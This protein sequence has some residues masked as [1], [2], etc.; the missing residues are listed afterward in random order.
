MN[1]WS[2]STTVRNPERIPDFCTAVEAVAE[3]EWNRSSQ[4]EFMYE[5]IRRRFYEPSNMTDA[6]QKKF[7]DPEYRLSRNEAKEIFDEQNYEDPP[8]RGRT[9][10]APL[11]DIGVV[12]IADRVRVTSIGQ[13]LIAGTISLQDVLLNYALKW[14]VPTPGHRRFTHQ[15]GFNIRPFVGVLALIT[16]VNQLW[17]DMGNEAVGVSKEEFEIFAPTLIAHEHIELFAQRIISIR[18]EVRSQRSAAARLAAAENGFSQ[19]L[20]WCSPNQI[21]TQTDRNNLRDFGDNAIRYFRQTGFIEHR[22]AGR[23][24]DIAI[25]VAPQAEALVA[26]RHH[27]PIGFDDEET[28]QDYVSDLAS[29]TPPWADTGQLVKVKNHLRR[30]LRAAGAEVAIAPSG[31]GGVVNKI[32]GEDQEII[33]LRRALVDFRLTQL[34]RR[35]RHRD[36]LDEIV[37]E[38]EQLL[39]RN[40][41]GYLPKP[42]ALEFNTFKTFLSLNDAV[43]VT[44]NFPTGDDGEPIST[45]PGGATDLICEYRSF[46]LSVEVTLSRGNNQWVMEGQPVQRHLRQIEDQ[47][48]KPVY[49]L[50]LAPKLHEDTVETFWIAN[51]HGYQGEKQKIAA[52]ELPIWR[53]Y[54][55]SQRAALE[56]NDYGHQDLKILLESSLP[57]Q[58]LYRNSGEWKQAVNSEVFVMSFT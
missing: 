23:Y 26:G 24:V 29:F 17:S 18:Q 45:A 30:V 4:L 16:H 54:L 31:S 3:K 2:I 50:F 5:L 25:A 42:V 21:V 56:S 37:L 57:Q 20:N 40:Y 44:A 32:R 46:V 6:Q 55:Q 38:Y 41:G 33:G 35:S 39:T 53:S 49:A 8:M 14:E 15:N 12:R 7:D 34:K 10:I 28:Y 11:R 48:Q 9:A 52:L 19:H 13:E 27:V 22:G 36:F 47:Y 58:S 43:S 51:L 1:V